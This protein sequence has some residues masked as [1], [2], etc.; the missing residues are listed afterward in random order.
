MGN[1]IQKKNTSRIA[2]HLQQVEPEFK[3][4]KKKK[5]KENIFRRVGYEI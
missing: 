4:K 1:S 2:C 5:D 3:E